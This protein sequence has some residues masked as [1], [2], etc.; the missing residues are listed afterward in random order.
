MVKLIKKGENNMSIVISVALQKGGVGKTTT[1]HALASYL[2]SKNNK[3]LLVDMDAQG[4]V[5]YASGVEYVNYTIYEV[6]T[7]ECSIKDA[8]KNTDYF[9]IIP[10]DKTLTNATVEL[11]SND[12]LRLTERLDQVKPMYD[13]IIIDTPPALGV[14]SMN[15][16]VASDYILIPTESSSYALQGIGELFDTIGA[17][18]Q[19]NPKL[20]VL[21]IV[22]IKY[23]NR[24]VLNRQLKEMIEDFADKNS[25]KVFKT[26][27]REGIAVK[28]AQTMQQ[29]LMEYAPKS[30]PAV[31]YK[32]LVD[33][34][35][36]ELR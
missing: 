18:K 14:L 26:F 11:E 23:N 20:K 4:N 3:V 6:L 9:D 16:F 5:S 19:I 36:K 2:G 24:V 15:S 29:S 31:D 27:I 7:N 8:I 17:V 35:I 33:E 1:S 32:H 12:V 13:F 25:V 22:L 30:K 21:G 34:I 10:A 28:E